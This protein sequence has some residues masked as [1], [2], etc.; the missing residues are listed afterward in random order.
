MYAFGDDKQVANDT[1]AVM[2]EI[3]I[4]YIIDVVRSYLSDFHS[5]SSAYSRLL[6]PIDYIIITAVLSKSTSPSSV[7]FY[8]CCPVT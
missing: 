6:F 5:G 8:H 3:L 7:A 2:E 1:V 4:E